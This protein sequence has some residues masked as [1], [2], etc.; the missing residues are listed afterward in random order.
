MERS[1]LVVPEAIQTI[2]CFFIHSTM[3]YNEFEHIISAERM[4]K[5]VVACGGDTRRAMTLYRWNLK[6]SQEMFTMI[7]CFE[8]ALRNKIDAEM[9]QHW[10]ND[11]LRDFMIPGGPFASDGRVDGTRK[12]IRKAYDSLMLAGNYSHA[13][14]LSQMEFGVCAVSSWWPMSVKHLSK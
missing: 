11:W 1:V 7:S 6:L 3:V 12:I 14:L 13:K 8:V 2:R 5:Y 4:R 9:K 10:G